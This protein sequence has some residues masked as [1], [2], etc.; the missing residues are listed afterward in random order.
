MKSILDHEKRM[1]D[2]L[3]NDPYLDRIN[4]F[5]SEKI[6]TSKQLDEYLGVSQRALSYWLD[7]GVV[8]RPPKEGSWK[9][10]TLGDY[11]WIGMIKAFRKFDLSIDSLKEIKDQLFQ[12]INVNDISKLPQVKNLLIGFQD[13]PERKELAKK[14]I[15]S[16][17]F[18]K[19]LSQFKISLFDTLLTNLLIF[20]DNLSLLVN[21]DGVI[22][23]F[24]WYYLENYLNTP[25]TRK[26]IEG[27]YY[28]FS[29]SN[30]VLKYIENIPSTEYN[31]TLCFLRDDEIQV[32][33]S[34]RK[35]GIKEVIVKFDANNQINLIE[36]LKTEKIELGKRVSE[37]MI[38][39]GYQSIS[40]E[41]SGGKPVYCENR[42][43]KRI[44]RLRKSEQGKLKLN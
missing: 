2:Q 1:F 44:K 18:K 27:D 5:L 41:V 30:I 10:F 6:I 14:I 33:Q 31:K 37:F 38:K 9:K 32:L 36:E 39:G 26:F 40:I 4:E 34:L 13:S 35:D 15:D 3:G 43:K 24:K 19:V 21:P 28:S 23:P 20:R 16:D 11:A 25:R 42:I 29:V 8:T 17:E 12:E 22:L 7:E